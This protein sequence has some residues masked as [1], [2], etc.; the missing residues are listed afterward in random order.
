MS[1]AGEGDDLPPET[2]G[3]RF[4]AL[5]VIGGAMLALLLLGIAFGIAQYALRTTAEFV[6]AADGPVKS[7]TVES[8]R[9]RIELAADRPEGARMTA[10]LTYFARRPALQDIR[11]GASLEIG[12]DCDWPSNCTLRVDGSIQRGSDV[13]IRTTSGGALIEGRPGAVNVRS[14][15]GAVTVRDAQRDVNVGT[16][17][18]SVVIDGAR[19]AVRAESGSGGVTLRE[20][21][22]PFRVRAASGVVRG[23]ALRSAESQVELASGRVELQYVRPPER[24]EIDIGEGFVEI[25]IPA[26]AYRLDI[27]QSIGD[28]RVVGI[29][30]DPAADRRLTVRVNEGNISIRGV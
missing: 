2:G 13:R 29:R 16:R 28:R 10:T 23:A 20:L 19:Q 6:V 24:I 21:E 17:S 3:N 8:D 12:A 27:E 25:E 7:V 15:N 5:L 1:A 14:T 30:D 22:G 18:G 26:G 11:E 4:R 9:G